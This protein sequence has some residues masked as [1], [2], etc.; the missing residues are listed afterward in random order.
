MTAITG[1][2][3][4]ALARIERLNTASARNVIE[5]DVEVT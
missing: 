3:A 4:R 1:V 2:D 5:P